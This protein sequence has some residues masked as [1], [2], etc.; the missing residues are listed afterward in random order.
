M[1][2]QLMGLR[3][4][5]TQHLFLDWQELDLKRYSKVSAVNAFFQLVHTC[6]ERIICP[7]RT[8]T[9]PWNVRSRGYHS[10]LIGG[11]KDNVSLSAFKSHRVE[12]C[13]QPSLGD[14]SLTEG[15]SAEE[16]GTVA[17]HG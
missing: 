5:L 11:G 17:V 7:I 2:L 13:S 1:W 12:E 6:I 4:R 15:K 14:V 10:R 8:R 16:S 9:F 3:A